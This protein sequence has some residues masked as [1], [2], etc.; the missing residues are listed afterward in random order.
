MRE[1]LQSY[2]K[3]IDSEVDWLG[4]IPRSWKISHIKRLCKKITDG[5]HTSPDLSSP[6]FPFITV[7]N[8]DRG[9]LDFQECL[10][11]SESDYKKL[12]RNGCKPHKFDVLYSKDGTISE[13]V[14]IDEDREFVVGSSVLP[15]RGWELYNE[16]L[17]IR[18]GVNGYS[19]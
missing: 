14:V 16:I 9:V 5:A 4:E 12:V 3:Y 19:S 2:E 1:A 8:L 13:T 17:L 7:V 6:D 18:D 11:T 15:D 10:C